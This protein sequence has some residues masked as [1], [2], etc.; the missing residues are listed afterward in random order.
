MSDLTGAVIVAA[1][2]I[3][4]TLVMWGIFTGKIKP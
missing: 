2:G 3:M 4:W 1:L